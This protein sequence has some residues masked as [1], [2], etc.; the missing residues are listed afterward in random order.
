[1]FP[2]SM[3]PF[4]RKTKWT[5]WALK[6]IIRVWVFALFFCIPLSLNVLN[7]RS[8][9]MLLHLEEPSQGLKKV[10]SGCLGLV[11]FSAEQLAFHSHL[12]DGQVVC[13]Q[14]P[15]RLAHCKLTLRA[16]IVQSFVFSNP[17][18][19]IYSNSQSKVREGVTLS[20]VYLSI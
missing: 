14:D 4:S 13:Q 12:P 3:L 1:M 8:I 19:L 5:A 7:E 16:A 18:I 17:C 15:K 20:T 9:P 2:I 11:Y 10:P 6:Q